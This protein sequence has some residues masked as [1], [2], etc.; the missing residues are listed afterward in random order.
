MGL[1][2]NVTT[3][4][5]Q[6]AILISILV[7]GGVAAAG[8]MMFGDERTSAQKKPTPVEPSLTGVV[9]AAFNA[10][11]S[12]SALTQQ[13]AKT[14]ALESLMTKLAQQVEDNKSSF[15]G[16]LSKKDEEI[17]RLTEQLAASPPRSNE[18]QGQSV[19]ANGTPLPNALSAGQSRPP[20]YT[21]TPLN[22]MPA[23]TG[24]VNMN[25]GAGFYPGGSGQR[26][27]GGLSSTV[28]TYDRMKKKPTKLPWIPSGSFSDAVMIEGA[29]ANASVTGQQNTTHVT[30]RLQGNITMPNNHEYDMDGCFVNGEIW[31]DISSERG[32]VRTKN[33]SCILKNGKNVDMAFQGHVSFQGKGGIKGKPVMRNGKIIGYAGAAGFLS[34][35]G[36]GVKSASTPTV[37]LGATA[38]V[39]GMDILKQGFGGGSEKAADNLSQYWIKLAEQYHPVLDIGAGNLVTVVFQEGFRLETLEDA[40]D[41]KKEGD[42]QQAGNSTQDTPSVNTGVTT[43]NSSVNVGNI[44]PDEI[45]RKARELRLGDTIN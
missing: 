23:A 1:N 16:R 28:F 26:T 29:D 19:G 33:I 21:V 7:V 11:V 41:K 44:N 40:D 24:A 30:F 3:R 8:V 9:T 45:L 2:V 39:S 35:I 13:Q 32:N 27:T 15:E 42:A 22:G 14:S 10:Q 20:E 6:I 12:E 37:G 18:S 38:S 34:G 43:T 31:G 17:R 5:K 36:S 4:K 25:Q